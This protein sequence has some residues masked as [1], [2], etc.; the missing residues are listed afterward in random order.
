MHEL[1][2]S[3]RTFLRN[4][5]GLVVL[6]STA[7]VTV[8]G[9]LLPQ[10]HRDASGALV[11]TYVLKVADYPALANVGGSVKL[12][13]SQQLLLNPDHVARGGAGR[14]FPIAVTRI[15]VT[16][17]AAFAAVSTYCTHGFD[18]QLRDFNAVTGQFTCPHRGATFSAEG[19]H[20][21][22]SGTPN[23]GNLRTF[24]ATFDE[25]AGTIT[26]GGV[27]QVADVDEDAAGP[28]T[29]SLD[30]NFPNPFYPATIIRF[31]LARASHAELTVHALDGTAIATLVD[32]HLPAGTHTMDFSG[33]GLPS[34]TY[35]YRLRAGG[36]IL[37]R[38]MT[39]AR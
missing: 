37:T 12:T 20:I 19:V 8:I 4:A 7:P 28:T 17:T 6:S 5:L 24:T 1:L 2:N 11:A 23:V 3:R 10:L 33:T 26:L 30:Q 18:Y 16:G 38:R 31:G 25:D 27:R 34:G 21:M 22:K 35:F 29:D 15:T 32:E 13:T 36:T 14:S 39:I 9:R